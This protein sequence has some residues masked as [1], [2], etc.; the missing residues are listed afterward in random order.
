[1]H[2]FI[3]IK[4]KPQILHELPRRIRIR[5]PIFHDPSFDV[6]Y[7]EAVLENIPGVE[8]VR[9]N[10]GTAS[11]VVEYNGNMACRKAIIQV[12]GSTPDEAFRP[13]SFR[14]EVCDPVGT[15]TKATLALLTPAFPRPL[16]TL[17]GW[18]LSLP[19]LLKGVETLINRGVRVKVLDAAVVSFSLM[20]R[21]YFTA[22]AI[23]A[24]LALGEYLEKLSENRATGLLKNLLRPQMEHAWIERGGKEIRIRTDELLIGDRVICGAGEMIPVDGKVD[25]GEASVNQSSITGES[26]PV[27]LQPGDDALSGSVIHEGRITIRAI[28]VGSDTGIAR[29]NRFLEHSLRFRSESEKKSDELAD[30]LVPATLG[31]GLALFLLTRDVRRAA[32]VLTVDYSCAIKLANPVVVKTAMY[33][34]AHRGVLLK[35]SQALDALAR[36]DTMVFDKTGTLTEGVLEVTHVISTGMLTSDELL[37]LAAAAEEHYAH[38]VAG[39]VVREASNR[40]LVLPPTAEVDFIVAHGVSA[41]ID[42]HRVLVGSR[43]FLDEDEGIDCSAANAYT[44]NLRSKGNTLLYVA[45]EHVLEGVIALRD[46]VRV[47]ASQAL[48]DLKA[49]GIK[50]IIMLTGDHPDTARA[51]SEKIE[52]LDEVRWDLKPE[53]KA[54]IIKDL[55]QQGCIIAFAGDGVNDAPALMTAEVG[56]CMPKGADLA[57]EAAQVVLL[58]EDLSALVEARRIACHANRTMQNCFWT[59]VGANSLFLL[60]AGIGALPPVTAAILHNANTVGIL[61]YAALSGMDPF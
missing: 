14:D 34:A 39:A 17:L 11:V 37:A 24:L 28:R 16:R 1:M 33:T 20:R 56:I 23:V 19:I 59:S 29:I 8:H 15:G 13:L 45:R 49:L 22:N 4:R 5:S 40:G 61:G 50:K 38:P 54:A 30:R 47:E 58:K 53:D 18:S 26:V 7:F 27:H 2:S 48:S 6:T 31:L 32:A 43:H 60:L 44:K 57:R 55:K 21:D 10:L 51:I 36:V 3:E 12:V 35:G 46:A 52:A 41:Y 9:F 42:G 25:N